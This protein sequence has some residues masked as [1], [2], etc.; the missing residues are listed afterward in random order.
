MT[1]TAT[2]I[3]SKPFRG[4]L[5]SP[6]AKRGARTS[7]ETSTP[8]GCACSSVSG[9]ARRGPMSRVPAERTA[10][11]T[12]GVAFSGGLLREGHESVAGAHE[13][14]LEVDVAVVDRLSS[15]DA[16]PA[17]RPA[18]ALSVGSA[19][20][21]RPLRLDY[22]SRDPRFSCCS[23]SQHRPRRSY[24]C[25]AERGHRGFF[26]RAFCQREFAEHGLN[27]VIAQAN[28][29]YNT[30]EGTLRGMHFQF[31]PAAET[32]LVRCTRG[33]ILDIIVDLRPESPTYLQHVSRRADRRKSPGFVRA[34]AVRARLPDAR[35]RHRDELPGRRVLHARQ[36]GGLRYDDPRLGLSGRCRSRRSRRRTDRGRC[37]ESRD[38]VSV[39]ST[40]RRTSS[41]DHRRHCAASAGGRG[42][43]DPRR[44]RRRRLHG[45][46]GS[47]TRS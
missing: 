33:A 20:V 36:E 40:T 31:P 26:A 24:R 13:D 10:T 41:D 34:G 28:V 6:R 18:I 37:S 19:R 29:A 12:L 17:L 2:C 30:R 7:P 47:R 9:N 14:R 23:R 35:R 3:C 22:P 39:M 16:S 21:P 38:R 4:R 15:N 46:R 1:A 42:R 5:A 32:K 45:R 27:P 11:V 43:P 8:R 25:R 44:L